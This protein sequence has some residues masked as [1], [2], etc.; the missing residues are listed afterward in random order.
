MFGCTSS[1]PLGV[2]SWRCGHYPPNFIY[3]RSQSYMLLSLSL[4]N[5]SDI[6]NLGATLGIEAVVVGQRI[7]NDDRRTA[8]CAACSKVYYMGDAL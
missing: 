1:G 5:I 4:R 6:C 8:N 7:S 3:T 2:A